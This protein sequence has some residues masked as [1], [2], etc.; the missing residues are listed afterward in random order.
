MAMKGCDAVIHLAAE[1]H[2]DRSIVDP[3]NFVRTNVYG[4]YVLLE[5]AKVIGIARIVIVSTDEVYGSIRKGSFQETD[6]LKPSSP[7]SASK[8]S[9]DMLSQAYFITYRLPIIIVRPTNNFGFN[10]HCEKLIPRSIINVLQNKKIKLF[11]DGLQCR[12][13]LFVLD[14]ASAIDLILTKGKIG[15]I[16]NIGGGKQNERTNLWMAKFILKKLKKKNG[17]IAYV[18]DRPGHDFRYSLNC[19][20]IRGL[21][22]QPKQNLENALKLTI[23]WYLKNPSYWRGYMKD[24]FVK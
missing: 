18:K 6:A 1:T 23:D 12:E 21:G 2:V 3:N 13:W 16:Y 10:Q 20:K 7:Y 15:E 9:A 8:A 5:V 14:C 22:W 19:Q 4:T 11:K 17:F 24:D